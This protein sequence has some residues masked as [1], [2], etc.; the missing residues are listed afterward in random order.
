MSNN[1]FNNVSST[2]FNNKSRKFILTSSFFVAVFSNFFS[3]SFAADRLEDQELPR[4]GSVIALIEQ[5]SSPQPGSSDNHKKKKDPK[6]RKIVFQNSATSVTV[7][8]ETKDVLKGLKPVHAKMHYYVPGLEKD[9]T[10]SQTRMTRSQLLKQQLEEGEI[11]GT[12]YQEAIIRPEI[13]RKRIKKHK[14]QGTTGV[15]LGGT[16][17]KMSSARNHNG[18][19]SDNEESSGYATD[20]SASSAI[21]MDLSD[22][23][24]Q[25]KK[26]KV[27]K[28]QRVTPS[29]TT[30]LSPFLDTE[31][32]EDLYDNLAR[33]LPHNLIFNEGSQTYY[34]V[35]DM[36]SIPR[37]DLLSAMDIVEERLNRKST[38]NIESQ[39]WVSEILNSLKKVSSVLKNSRNKSRVTV[40]P[41]RTIMRKG[42]Q[43]IY[44]ISIEYTKDNQSHFFV[45][46]LE[47][48][49]DR[50]QGEDV[51][52]GALKW[53]KNINK[54]LKKISKS[55]AE[56]AY[57]NNKFETSLLC[58][59]SGHE[60]ELALTLSP[61]AWDKK[62]NL[63]DIL[64]NNSVEIQSFKG[65]LTTFI[66]S[67]Y[68]QDKEIFLGVGRLGLKTGMASA[69]KRKLKR[70]FSYMVRQSLS[71]SA[72]KGKDKEIKSDVE[73]SGTSVDSRR[74]SIDSSSSRVNSR[75]GSV[76]S[77]NGSEMDIPSE[78]EGS[79]ASSPKGR[80]V[81]KVKLKKTDASKSSATPSEVKI[82]STVETEMNPPR[83]KRMKN[84]PQSSVLSTETTKA[85][86]KKKTRKADGLK[87]ISTS[88]QKAKKNLN[89]VESQQEVALSGEGSSSADAVT[90][91]VSEKPKRKKRTA[92][93]KA[94]Q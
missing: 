53:K 55:K 21:Y 46:S 1:I 61:E 5:F 3:S 60:Y 75:K 29:N 33:G 38:N 47:E 88:S 27:K 30:P 39:E 69:P 15:G 43:P 80:S 73:S 19:S 11:T 85:S 87:K 13:G 45:L 24:G 54:F 89:S 41:Q 62:I 28:P 59:I 56:R 20:A 17:G 7:P 34:A 25:S 93:Q 74:G 23:E 81:K 72:L 4:K 64:G 49:K 84:L 37:A 31:S 50:F 44:P 8:Q 14:R 48:P 42:K 26:T 9:D 77:R 63:G 40:T 66:F 79:S 16:L 76:S 18:S 92:H 65:N 58:P 22:S 78:S 94:D 52:K 32:E 57:T 6:R 68:T 36:A 10:V 90:S 35:R 67:M 12:E 91:K 51:I 83:R 70:D 82:P 2:I 71:Q 86:V